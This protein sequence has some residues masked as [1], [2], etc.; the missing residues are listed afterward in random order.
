MTGSVMAVA[1]A[2]LQLLSAV[3]VTPDPGGPA[4]SLAGRT[5]RP[6]TLSPV[7]DN[8]W[9]PLRPGQRLLYRGHDARGAIR[10]TM[11]VRRQRALIAGVPCTAVRITVS[12]KGVVTRRLTE[13]YAEDVS[14]TVW[15]KG[16]SGHSGWR[17]GIAGARPQPILRLDP[18]GGVGLWRVLDPG[19]PVSSGSDGPRLVMIR[20]EIDVTV[21][22]GSFTGGV[23]TVAWFP[24]RAGVTVT[25][26]APM[27]GVV[28][29]S[30]ASLDLRLVEIRVPRSR[31]RH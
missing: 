24:F 23:Q 29:L 19:L 7:V 16:M 1:L 4:V 14:G 5:A 6:D 11:A 8:P 15:S 12:R 18:R 20:P 22:F 31:D 3:A 13:W 28:R 9:F 26:F 17:A 25:R 27:I 30:S 2:M 10:L 21:P